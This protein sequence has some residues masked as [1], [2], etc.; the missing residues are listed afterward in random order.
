MFPGRLLVPDI[1]VLWTR[2][3]APPGRLTRI[4][5]TMTAH[6]GTLSL[7]SRRQLLQQIRIC[8]DALRHNPGSCPTRDSLRRDKARCEAEIARR[9]RIESAR[10]LSKSG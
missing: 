10:P 5:Q 7:Y 9:D 2:S 6:H 4:H 3:S 8:Q 1:P